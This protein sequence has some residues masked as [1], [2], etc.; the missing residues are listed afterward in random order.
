[1]PTAHTH[2]DATCEL[3]L[4]RPLAAIRNEVAIV[5]SL[6]DEVERLVPSTSPRMAT[7][8]LAEELARLANQLIEAASVLRAATDGRVPFDSSFAAVA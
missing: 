3:R 5:R 1:M 7:D 8:Q 6:A 2:V 4:V